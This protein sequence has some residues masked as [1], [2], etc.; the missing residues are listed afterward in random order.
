[1]NTDAEM[2]QAMEH[3]AD[4]I[5]RLAAM[6]DEVVALTRAG[7]PISA[8]TIDRYAAELERL[9]RERAALRDTLARFW[10]RIG[11]MDAQ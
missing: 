1:M 10:A 5:D 4:Q 6:L 7:L 11:K 8:Q 9:T 2:L 3:L